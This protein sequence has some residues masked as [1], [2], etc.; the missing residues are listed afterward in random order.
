MNNLSPCY[1]FSKGGLEEYI[2]YDIRK[3]KYS[4]ATRHFNLMKFI[5]RNKLK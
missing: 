3:D 1:F 2:R 5:F 4:F